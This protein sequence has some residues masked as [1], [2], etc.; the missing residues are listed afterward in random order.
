MHAHTETHTHRHTVTHTGAHTYIDM[1]PYIHAHILRYT[2]TYTH[3]KTCIHTY[4]H[5]H[6]LYILRIHG[7]ALTDIPYPFIHTHTHPRVHPPTHIHTH[8]GLIHSGRRGNLR[9][10]TYINQEVTAGCW[11]MSI[12]IQSGTHTTPQ[13]CESQESTLVKG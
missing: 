9:R 10:L 5:R 13:L 1:Y 7:H 12:P 4:T 6:S 8:D 2:L 3:T 11:L